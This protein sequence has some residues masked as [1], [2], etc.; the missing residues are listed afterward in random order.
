MFQAK[1]IGFAILGSAL[2][3]MFV[4]L[5]AIYI[6]KP[7]H[8]VTAIGSVLLGA[9]LIYFEGPKSDKEA[10]W[11]QHALKAGLFTALLL[12]FQLFTH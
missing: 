12:A 5:I 3:A 7:V 2:G 4:G 9:G 1:K 8:L 10:N 11:I 6:E